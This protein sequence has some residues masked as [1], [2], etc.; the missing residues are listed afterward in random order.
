MYELMRTD[1]VGLALVLDLR[2]ARRLP[3]LR[4]WFIDIP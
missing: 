4:T 1:L 3:T 2:D